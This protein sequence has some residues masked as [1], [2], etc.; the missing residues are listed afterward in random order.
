MRDELKSLARDAGV[1]VR[2]IWVWPTDGLVANAAVMG[3]LP[4]LRCVML[5]DCLLE[6]M[7]R[8]QI[9]AVMAHELGHVVRRHLVWMIAVVLGCWTLA[10]LLITPLAQEMYERMAAAAAD[11]SQSAVL[12]GA[13]LARDA[14]VLALGLVA[15]GF[16]SRRFERQADTFAV[17]LLSEREDRREATPDAVD[18]MVGALGSVALLNHVPPSRSSWR[19][20]S[21]AWRQDYLRRLTGADHRA[22]PID[23]LVAALRWGSVVVVAVGLLRGIVPI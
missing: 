1:G 9:H 3:V 15:F 11:D 6:S 8:A 5:S 7:P 17:Q 12:H 4:G 21:I 19:H 13:A 22:L 18:A 14:A 2:E 16:A 10:S 20:G 23:S